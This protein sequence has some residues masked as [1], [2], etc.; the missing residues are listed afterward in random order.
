MVDDTWELVTDEATGSPTGGPKPRWLPVTIT[1]N[2]FRPRTEIRYELP[3]PAAVQLT[4]HDASGALVRRLLGGAQAAGP[5]AVAWDGR[6]DAGA[7]L[8][9]G[10]YFYRLRVDGRAASGSIVLLR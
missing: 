2:P 9:S 6:D 4:I 10:K 1:P 5:H 7:A 3:A 8:P